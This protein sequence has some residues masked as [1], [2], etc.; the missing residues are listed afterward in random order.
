MTLTTISSF[1]SLVFAPNSLLFFILNLMLLILAIIVVRY[2]K[3]NARQ[4]MKKYFKSQAHE[5]E[6]I[7]KK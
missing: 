7:L 2:H 1:I 6:K 4:I 3:I 5:I